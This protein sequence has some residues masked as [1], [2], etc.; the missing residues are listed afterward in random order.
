MEL[1]KTSYNQIAD[2]WAKSRKN[3]FLSELIID[4]TDK[5]KPEGKVLDIGCGTGYPI[6]D[7]LANSGFEITGID[8]SKSMLNKAIELHLPKSQ[9][10]LTDFFDFNPTGLFDGIIAF[11]SFF[12]FPFEGQRLIYPKVAKWL[13]PG[14][15]LLFTHGLESSEIISEMFGKTFYYSSLDK[16]EVKTLLES[17]GLEIEKSMEKYVEKDM[18]RDWVVFCRKK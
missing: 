6:A 14:G 13:K 10:L 8:F 12:H 17:N 18:D 16:D 4:F 5:I 3:S 7:Y 15:V 11:D 2:D 1:N 9:F